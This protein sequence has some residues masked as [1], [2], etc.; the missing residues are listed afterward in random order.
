[1]GTKVRP[2]VGQNLF[3]EV[4]WR[5]VRPVISRTQRVCTIKKSKSPVKSLRS[6]SNQRGRRFF[7]QPG[8]ER[9]EVVGTGYGV[10]RPGEDAAR[11]CRGEGGDVRGQRRDER[12]SR[13]EA[14][15]YSH[16]QYVV[17][18]PHRPC[19]FRV[20]G[21]NR[22]TPPW[23]RWWQTNLSVVFRSRAAISF[24]FAECACGWWGSPSSGWQHRRLRGWK[25][26]W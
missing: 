5:P 1:M 10:E 11:D 24:I 3:V 20:V 8:Y 6:N 25:V 26:R 16:P 13:D 22:N 7:A 23:T 17:M 21:W 15:R 2:L 19:Q 18:S 4:W 12:R 14:G 9:G